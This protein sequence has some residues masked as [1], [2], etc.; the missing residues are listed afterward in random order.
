MRAIKQCARKKEEQGE[1]IPN[2]EAEKQRK[3]KEGETEED[4]Q[5]PTKTGGE[6]ESGE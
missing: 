2:Y 1:L 3:K 4:Y 6:G 5:S